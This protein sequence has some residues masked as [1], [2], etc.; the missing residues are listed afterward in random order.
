MMDA[1][2][3]D[4]LRR[5]SAAVGRLSDALREAA[6]GLH[7]A[8]ETLAA[9]APTLDVEVYGEAG[10]PFGPVSVGGPRVAELWAGFGQATTRN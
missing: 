3:P 2:T 8:A 1:P 6:E 10:E 4:D 7:A 5:L 9:A